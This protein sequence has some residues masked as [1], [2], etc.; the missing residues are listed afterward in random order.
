[1]KKSRDFRIKYINILLASW[2]VPS[3][4]S[5]FFVYEHAHLTADYRGRDLAS[6]RHRRM[7]K[8]NSVTVSLERKDRYTIRIGYRYRS[9]LVLRRASE[10]R[11]QLPISGFIGLSLRSIITS[12]VDKTRARFFENLAHVYLPLWCCNNFTFSFLCGDASASDI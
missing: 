10:N 1:M 11:S 2:E 5:C 7:G 8:A 6:L 12:L 3:L 9:S 4:F